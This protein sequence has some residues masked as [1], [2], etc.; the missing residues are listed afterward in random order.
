MHFRILYPIETFTAG[1]ACTAGL[2][3]YCEAGT[4]CENQLCKINGKFEDEVFQLY[5]IDC[6]LLYKNH[7]K[8]IY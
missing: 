3:R 1:S 7:K 8:D 5:N 2:E 4:T 6:T